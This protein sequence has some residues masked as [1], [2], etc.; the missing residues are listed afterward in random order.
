MPGSGRG[1]LRGFLV[2]GGGA[3]ERRVGGDGGRRVGGDGGRRVG[4]GQ[5][6]ATARVVDEDGGG[7][8][9]AHGGLAVASGRKKK[10]KGQRKIGRGIEGRRK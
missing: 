10:G 6:G 1:A 2:A 9:G 5:G 3:R 7:V 8:L 4:F